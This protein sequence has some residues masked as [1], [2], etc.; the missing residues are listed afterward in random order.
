MVGHQTGGVYWVKHCLEGWVGY[1]GRFLRCSWGRVI[2]RL[3]G[4]F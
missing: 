2:Q 1:L 3:W 4:V